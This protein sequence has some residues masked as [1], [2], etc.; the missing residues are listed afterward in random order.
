MTTSE[1]ALTALNQSIAAQTQMSTAAAE[2]RPGEPTLA[3]TWRTVAQR[4]VTDELL[5]WPPDVFAFTDGRMFPD[6][7]PLSA[8]I[9]A[10]EA[11]GEPG[12][13]CD[14]AAAAEVR[15]GS[16]G[17]AAG[18]AGWPLFG[19]LVPHDI[20]ADRSPVG[21]HAD[22]AALRNART[23]KLNLEMVYSDGPVGAPPTFT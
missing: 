18:A 23:P 13:L 10:L 14:A 19:Q 8:D 7:P 16:S 21:P 22:V 17:D 2:E 1:N 3:S 12:G 4:P 11:A 9:S 15:A 20:A 5:A 6:L